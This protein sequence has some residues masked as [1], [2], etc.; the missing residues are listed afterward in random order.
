MRVMKP[1]RLRKLVL[2]IGEHRFSLQL[3][4][5]YDLYRS[6]KRLQLPYCRERS[7]RDIR[8]IDL[9][10]VRP[11]RREVTGSDFRPPT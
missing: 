1:R 8:V 4:D 10:R 6:L 9:L 2:I 3:R 5:A 11:R 7:K